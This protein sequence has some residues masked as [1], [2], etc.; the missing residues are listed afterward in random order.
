M[1]W[2][3]M[4]K[5]SMTWC[6]RNNLSLELKSLIQASGCTSRPCSGHDESNVVKSSMSMFFLL[7]ELGLLLPYHVVVPIET[8][9]DGGEVVVVVVD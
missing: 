9:D 6:K 1:K 5:W 3:V 2:S 8:T 4:V 7:R